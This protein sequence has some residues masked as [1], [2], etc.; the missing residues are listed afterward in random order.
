MRS[1]ILPPEVSRWMQKKM[2]Q[3]AILDAIVP[4][5]TY[6]LC[7]SSL[8]PRTK[9]QFVSLET[10]AE[11]GNFDEECNHRLDAHI[12]GKI[13]SQSWDLTVG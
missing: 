5:S 4:S 9:M 13:A 2:F 6:I 12:V 8:Q 11:V 1:I 10:Q 7:S 3:H